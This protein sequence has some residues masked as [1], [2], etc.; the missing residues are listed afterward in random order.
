MLISRAIV[1]RLLVS[2][3]LM[4]ATIAATTSSASAFAG[5]TGTLGDPYQ[6]SSCAQLL[7]IDDSVANLAKAYV[8]TANVDCNGIAVTP[9]LNGST[10]FSGN[11]NGDGKTISNV[12]VSCTT[13]GC[14]LFTRLAGATVRNINL[15][16]FSATSTGVSVGTLA[17]L[18]SGSITLQN[19]TVINATVSGAA[20]VGGLVGDCAATCTVSNVST[21]G[22]I[23]SAG[24]Y[25][26]GI[27]AS[28]GDS[29]SHLSTISNSSS[30]AVISGKN[31]A[32]GLLGESYRIS[33]SA[34]AGV[35]N[36]SFSGT[37]SQLANTNHSSGG[38]VG[39]LTNMAVTG[40]R[41]TGS[42]SGGD[43][44]GGIVGFLRNNSTIATS[45]TSGSVV[46]TTTTCSGGAGGVV[47]SSEFGS[48]SES[49]SIA[50]VSGVCRSGGVE[51]NGVAALNNVFFRGSLTRTSGTDNS[52]GGISGRG[53]GNITNAYASTTNSYGY[54]YGISG[55]VQYSKTCTGS[56]WN[57]TTSGRSSTLCGSGGVS[58]TS[59]QLKDQ[60]T[61]TGWDFSTIWTIDPAVN[62]G[63][64][65]LRSVAS[66]GA[67][68]TAPTASWSSPSS[69]S[70]TRTLSY[71]L[72][73]SETVSGIAASDFS[74][75]GTAT[76]CS[77]APTATSANT[78][79][80][81]NVTCSSDGTVVAR[82]AA[83]SVVDAALN[84]GPGTVT[85]A[86]TVTINAVTTTT[87]TT[88]TSVVGSTTT[89]PSPVTS[90][91][92]TVAKPG[93]TSGSS[94]TVVTSNSS[95]SAGVQTQDTSTTTIAP[96]ISLPEIDVPTTEV[97]GASAL[98]GGT[99][100]AATITRANNELRV[101]VGF[102]YA[103]I[104]AEAQSGGRVPL[105]SDGRLRLMPGDSVTVD[106][107]GF[108][109]STPV[110]VRLYSDPLLL[111]RSQV[112]SSGMLSGS[113]EIPKQAETGDHTVVMVGTGNGED[114]TL[115]LSVAIG[116]EPDGVSPLVIILPIGLAI[117]VAMLLPVVLRR[118][119][120][121]DHV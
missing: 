120:D 75:T 30:S 54:G 32:G 115:G 93:S 45:W 121:Q 95:P 17:G 116:N 10:Y 111:G 2:V 102:I 39:Y 33:Y 50:A 36:S 59:T 101:K 94:T 44:V 15:E 22:N 67:D 25:V 96:K 14:G 71:T 77:F 76:P 86:S 49:Y 42:V 103:R 90:T 52:F 83:N 21:S 55:D 4:T 64:P 114:V 65:Y 88:S 11:L 69:P 9:M 98:I 56:Y 78:S 51:G 79:V 24:D 82:L 100:V 19:I 73:F 99:E 3:G 53:T 13:T 60:N 91:S 80:T 106:L 117:L 18:T 16:G 81:V 57:T 27:L 107:E 47:G 110:E 61:F 62:D 35:F 63:Y 12:S 29:S 84:T 7:M 113:Y 43:W 20:R 66:P 23:T 118:R 34:S 105:D 48:V 1:T 68:V 46:S 26:G 104:W 112:N 85:A 58:K 40:S 74:A 92:T 72:T 109:A 28:M 89:V 119:K 31:Y 108:D 38:I 87:S 37:V 6:V 70:A 5:G 8:L 41:S 97:G